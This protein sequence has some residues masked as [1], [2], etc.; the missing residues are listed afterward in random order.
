MWH[1][2]EPKPQEY[3]YMGGGTNKVTWP[4]D[5]SGSGPANL[6]EAASQ[7]SSLLVSGL[8]KCGSPLTSGAQPNVPNAANPPQSIPANMVAEARKLLSAENRSWAGGLLIYDDFTLQKTTANWG[9]NPISPCC[10]DITGGALV[11][12]R[13]SNAGESHTMSLRRFSDFIFAFALSV[14]PAKQA[15]RPNSGFGASSSPFTAYFRRGDGFLGYGIRFTDKET[16]FVRWDRV[17]QNEEKMAKLGEAFR[18]I[19][20]TGKRIVVEIRCRQDTIDCWLDGRRV[21]TQRDSE[22]SVGFIEMHVF[23]FK[24]ETFR[25][26]KAA[27][28]DVLK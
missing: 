20:W 26:E 2:F 3:H 7:V 4:I 1:K 19:P 27:V 12:S 28:F 10:P 5:H 24:G 11:F 25:V 9:L 14:M 13:K 18:A 23:W 21:A 17:D 16:S 15:P 22:Y 6:E 8:P